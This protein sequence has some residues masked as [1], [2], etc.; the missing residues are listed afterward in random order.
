MSNARSASITVITAITTL[1]GLSDG[2]TTWRKV[3][4]SLLPSS[5]RRFPQRAVD[6]L[7]PGQ[8]E[9]HDV[10]GVPPG[11]RDQN[12]DEVPGDAVVIA[13]WDQERLI[14]EPVDRSPPPNN[15]GGEAVLGRVDDA[16]PHE[17]DDRQREHDRGEEDALEEPGAANISSRRYARQMPSAVGPMKRKISRTELLISAWKKFLWKTVKIWS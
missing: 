1:I 7:Q 10:A 14:A 11:D 17:A 2:K 6:A 12:R 5:M 8:V 16:L 15:L 9:H 4:H 13:E 3:C